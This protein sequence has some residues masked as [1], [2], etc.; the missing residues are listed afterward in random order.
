MRLSDLVIISFPIGTP[1][2]IDTVTLHV[3][4]NFGDRIPDAS[5]IN[6]YITYLTAI[7]EGLQGCHAY[8]EKIADF[9]R[10]HHVG[11]SLSAQAICQYY[12][13]IA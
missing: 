1:I 2:I 9:G 11:S 4:D 7:A 13:H 5:V 12:D 3:T 10:S 6:S 8:M